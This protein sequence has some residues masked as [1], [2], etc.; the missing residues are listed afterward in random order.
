ML[1]V[2]A[3]LAVMVKVVLISITLLQVTQGH[4][5]A[6]KSQPLAVDWA[7]LVGLTG[8]VCLVLGVRSLVRGWGREGPQDG[9]M[10]MALAGV[11]GLVLVSV[12]ASGEIMALSVVAM[13][14]FSALDS[15]R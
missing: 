7:R 6:G 13:F 4:G 1:A 10:L 12:I 15:I 2:L 14:Y 11:G 5:F 3:V 8:L 9:A